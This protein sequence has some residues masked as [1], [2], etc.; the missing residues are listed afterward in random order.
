M[1][2]IRHKRFSFFSDQHKNA[3]LKIELAPAIDF[4]EAF[5]QATYNLEGD[6]SMALYVMRT[7][8]VLHVWLLIQAYM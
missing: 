8:H 5:V 3:L 4:G 7:L 2:R 6:G 1:H